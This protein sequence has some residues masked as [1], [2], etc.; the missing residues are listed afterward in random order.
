ME[1]R[2][3]LFMAALATLPAAVAHAQG[4]GSTAQRDAKAPPTDATPGPAVAPSAGAAAKPG[5]RQNAAKT[6]AAPAEPSNGTNAVVLDL[7]AVESVIGMPVKSSAGED[8]GHLVDILVTPQGEVRAAVIDF[9]GVLG[10]GSR[11]VAVDWK[12]LKFA[13]EGKDSQAV[14]ALTRNQVRVAPEYKS[15]DPVVVLELPKG[16][17]SKPKLEPKAAAHPA[18]TPASDARK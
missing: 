8:M 16:D 6:E 10:V 17:E 1:L 2:R 9:G 7:N 3:V 15:G 14:L 12:T 11:K 5:N 13:G 18:G 4:A